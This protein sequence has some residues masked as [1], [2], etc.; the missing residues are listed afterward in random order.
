M[1]TEYYIGIVEDVKDPEKLGR[2]KARFYGIH[3]DDRVLLP[4]VDLPWAVPIY[5][6]TSASLSGIGSSHGLLQGSTVLAFFLDKEKMQPAILGTLAGKSPDKIDKTRGFTDPDAVYPR[7]SYEGESDLPR[8]SRNQKIEETFVDKDIEKIIDKGFFANWTAPKTQYD[9]QYP[10]NRVRETESGHIEEYDDTPGRER[11]NIRHRMGTS[12]EINPDGS[13]TVKIVANSYT[14]VAGNNYIEVEMDHAET[15]KGN[16]QIIIKGSAEVLVEGNMATKIRGNLCEYIEGDAIRQVKGKL[17]MHSD[18]HTIV[19]GARVDWN[20]D[21]DVSG[22]D[23]CPDIKIEPIDI[24]YAEQDDPAEFAPIATTTQEYLN[25]RSGVA[26]IE[27]NVEEEAVT[28]KNNAS[29]IPV[30]CDNIPDDWDSNTILVSSITIGDLSTRAVYPHKVKAQN[31]LSEKEIICNLK[32]LA[33]NILLPFYKRYG[34]KIVT[35]NSGFRSG[36]GGSQHNKG[37]AVDL[38]M[39]GW[40]PQDYLKAAKWVAENLPCDQVIL[41]KAKGYWIHISYNAKGNR[42]QQLTLN[43]KTQKFDSGLKLYS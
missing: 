9:A 38:Q 26:G 8:T 35:I 12:K 7:D 5:P 20:P 17:V 28:E 23:L 29:N 2:V 32:N 6:I 15:I 4:T 37:Q 43:P 27:G 1:N 13:Q 41:E 33:E 22:N 24:P 21:Y 3:N 42:K 16:C 40:T 30:S 31:G 34:R 39:V 14:L 10:S 36:G 25:Q 11:I 18:T 19:Q